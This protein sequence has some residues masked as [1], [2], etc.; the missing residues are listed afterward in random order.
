VTHPDTEVQL[1]AD[2]DVP[3]GRVV[4]VIGAA[5]VAGLGRIAFVARV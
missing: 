3:Y 2:R 5:Q 4:E 1:R